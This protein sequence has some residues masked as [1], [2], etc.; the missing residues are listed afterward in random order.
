MASQ[1][2]NVIS[3]R[4]SALMAKGVGKRWRKCQTCKGKRGEYVI[5]KGQRVWKP[6][7]I[8]KGNGGIYLGNV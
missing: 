7:V 4:G 2:E 8:C 5:Q 6:C 3:Q 1:E